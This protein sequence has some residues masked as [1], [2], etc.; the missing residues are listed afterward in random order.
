MPR[1]INV[2]PLPIMG[3]FYRRSVDLGR[4][5]P[6]STYGNYYIMVMIEHL[7]KWVEEV[8]IPSKKSSETARM[9][10]QYVFCRYGAP[11]EVLTDQGTEL[12][13]EFQEMLDEALIDHRKTSRAHPKADGL[14]ERMV[15]TL[16]VALRKVCLEGKASAW[17]DRLATIAM[18]YRM[19]TH[20][21]L[22][23]FSPYYLLFGQSQLL[24]RSVSNRLRELDEQNRDDEKAWVQGV[25]ERADMFKR[26]IPMAMKNL[27]TA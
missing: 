25:A 26:A 23:H 19:S 15:P 8:A 9:F 17:E 1:D 22:A 14:A 11:A 13:G 6:Q 5:F 27:V 20:E 24:G 12:Q 2:H 16:K 7:S 10:R 3:M 4:S 18:G 21:S